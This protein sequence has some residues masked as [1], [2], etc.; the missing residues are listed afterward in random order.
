MNEII[1]AKNAPAAIG[2]YSHA[3]KA[4][5]FLFTSGQIALI[6]ETGKIAEGGIEAQAKQVFSNI[7]A[8]LAAAGMDYSDVIKTTVFLTDLADFAAVNKLYGELF[9]A[10]PPARSCVQVAALPGGSK[11]EMEVI[12]RK[13]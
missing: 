4:G 10:N 1:S 11:I 12:A 7:R 3:V 6:P 2:P 8:V 13:A 9:P 5:E